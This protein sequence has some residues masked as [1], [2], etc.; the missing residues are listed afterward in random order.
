MYSTTHRPYMI[1]KAQAM[2]ETKH[3]HTPTCTIRAHGLEIFASRFNIVGLWCL[4]RAV[5]CRCSN[6]VV[7]SYFFD[8][9]CHDDTFLARWLDTMGVR[10]FVRAGVCVF[11]KSSNVADGFP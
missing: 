6:P 8:V 7:T 11:S 1:Q 5:R 4:V 10:D 3:Y 2:A 9:T